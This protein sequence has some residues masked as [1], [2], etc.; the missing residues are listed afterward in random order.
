LG[1]YQFQLDAR[2][3]DIVDLIAEFGRQIDMISVTDFAFV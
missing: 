2:W 1:I 3:P